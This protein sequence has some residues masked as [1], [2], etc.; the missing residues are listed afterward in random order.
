MNANVTAAQF[1]I[2]WNDVI[3]GLKMAVLLPVLT[4]IYTSIQAGSFHFDWHAI[5]LTAAGGFIAYL[6]KNFFDAPQI[7]ITNAPK[8]TIEAVKSGA[9]ISV[10]DKTTAVK[11]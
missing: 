8:G 5:G 9:P 3:K 11:Q 6:I 10:D 4:I 7:V 1:N 2:N